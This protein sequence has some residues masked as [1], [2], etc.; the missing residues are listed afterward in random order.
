VRYTVNFARRIGSRQGDGI[1]ARGGVGVCRLSQID[2]GCDGG[3]IAKVPEIGDLGRARGIVEA[4]KIRGV[5]VETG[6]IR[7]AEACNQRAWERF[8]AEAG[9]AIVIE[10]RPVLLIGIKRRAGINLEKL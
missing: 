3:A 9:S 6:A 1:H 8:V 5:G 10:V 4:F 2:A 7:G